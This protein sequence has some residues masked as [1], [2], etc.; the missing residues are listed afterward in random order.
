MGVIPLIELLDGDLDEPV[1]VGAVVELQG[2]LSDA[3][4]AP[5]RDYIDPQPVVDGADDKT[6][7]RSR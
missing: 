5:V 4:S 7:L 6:V 1:R 3:I 2:L